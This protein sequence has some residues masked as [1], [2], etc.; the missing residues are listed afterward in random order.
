MITKSIEQIITSRK[1]KCCKCGEILPRGVPAIR[2]KFES[3]GTVEMKRTKIWCMKCEK[4]K[5][6]H[7]N[8]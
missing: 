4:A 6:E 3:T 1:T 8:E 2:Y 7:G 5:E